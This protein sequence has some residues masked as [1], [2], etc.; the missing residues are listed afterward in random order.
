[1]T[2]PQERI[3]KVFSFI[4]LASL[5]L[6]VS[7][8]VSAQKRGLAELK[9]GPIFENAAYTN[10]FLFGSGINPYNAN[11]NPS[12]A[13]LDGLDNL[14]EDNPPTDPNFSHMTSGWEYK[15][16]P[17]PFTGSFP[18]PDNP[19]LYIDVVASGSTITSWSLQPVSELDRQVSAII[20]KGGPNAN[21]YTYTTATTSDTSLLQT[22]SHPRP[23]Q[24]P[25][26]SHISFC[27]ELFGGTVTAADGTI[28]GRTIK[29]DGTG[30]A[31]ARVEV[32]N[33]STGEIRYAVTNPFGYYTFQEIETNDLYMV[34]VSH[35]RHQ[36]A[37]PQRM[38]NFDGDLVDLDFVAF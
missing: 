16:D 18:L 32:L 13:Y 4:A 2:N 11:G 21:V 7:M 36:F 15:I 9:T 12:C 20:V 22:P 19:N 26:I 8:P 17:G 10:V 1:M 25:G 24:Y 27:F 3:N 30:I 38:I 37:N 33:L 35:K 5:L 31:S 14:D 29:M 28:S 23:G 34:T 6:V